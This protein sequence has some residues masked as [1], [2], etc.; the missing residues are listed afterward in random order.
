MKELILSLGGRQSGDFLP[1]IIIM[2]RM[3]LL[4]AEEIVRVAAGDAF[5]A[6]FRVNQQEAISNVLPNLI[7]EL[8]ESAEEELEEE[9]DMRSTRTLEAVRQ[10]LMTKDSQVLSTVIPVLVQTP[11]SAK[12]LRWLVALAPEMQFGI[13]VYLDDLIKLWV[14]DTQDEEL[15]QLGAEFFGKAINERTMSL[16]VSKLLAAR[17]ILDTNIRPLRFRNMAFMSNH[18]INT[19]EEDVVPYMQLFVPM[20]VD[21]FM[22]EEEAT[23]RAG[24]TAFATF[25]DRIPQEQWHGKLSYIRDTIRVIGSP[26]V[27]GKEFIPAFAIHKGI[28]PFIDMFQHILS[29]YGANEK[30]D[31]ANFLDCIIKLCPPIGLKPYVK[32]LTGLFIRIL[33]ARH[34]KE[35]VVP[36]LENSR[37]L[38]R[39]MGMELKAFFP[40][41]L[42]VFMKSLKHSAENVRN[43][44]CDAVGLLMTIIAKK[45]IDPTVV[46]LAQSL[47]ETTE[48]NPEIQYSFV[49]ALIQVLKVVVKD[50]KAESISTVADAVKPLLEHDMDMIREVAGECLGILAIGMSDD[51][52]EEEIFELCLA[53]EGTWRQVHGKGVL[54]LSVLN[55]AF[56][57]IVDQEEALKCVEDLCEWDHSGVVPVGIDCVFGLLNGLAGDNQQDLAEQL[58]ELVQK[59]IQ[60]NLTQT[61]HEERILE[62]FAVFAKNHR[63]FCRLVQVQVSQ[64]LLQFVA[65]LDA[66]TRSMAKKALCEC[67]GSKYELND[68]I[69]S[70]GS[71]HKK[72]CESV[73]SACSSKLK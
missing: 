2:V 21:C 27:S 64:I 28:Q 58:L 19:T 49:M 8:E 42:K 73:F 68:W 20:F 70:A 4:D 33:G 57:K 52:F 17:D 59:D 55:N 67:F 39:K 18:Y 63:G 37:L 7:A 30:S 11:L 69:K 46:S 50:L 32:K 6:L 56:S 25:I 51:D 66:S 40:Q 24:L 26:D 45:R 23:Q 47:N 41:L 22:F 5:K 13:H 36:L 31:A 10:I 71:K 1:Q 15:L 12:R 53:L 54:F 35:V 3:T 16:F 48:E 9:G 61:S 44:A 34:H 65:S 62:G 43:K 72:L 29:G 60:P 38:L 14:H